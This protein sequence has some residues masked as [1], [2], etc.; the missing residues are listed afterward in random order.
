MQTAPWLARP[1][2]RLISSQ[3]TLAFWVK[4]EIVLLEAALLSQP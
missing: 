2:A 4:A 3:S 1:T